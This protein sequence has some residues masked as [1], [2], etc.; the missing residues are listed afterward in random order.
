VS[1]GVL[2]LAPLD[3]WVAGGHLVSNIEMDGR[4][5]RILTRADIAA[6]GLRLGKLFPASTL[7]AADTGAING[8]AKLHG[9]G[10]SVSQMMAGANG[11]AALVMDG[12]S[13]GELTVRLAN[14]D[15]ANSLLLLVGG[16]KQIPIR[17]AVANFKAEKGIF[18]V[19]DLVLDTTKV[20]I[21]GEGN[22]NFI[23]ESLHLRLLSRAKGFSLVTLR[24]PIAVTGSFQS[25]SVRP[26]LGGVFARGGLA[27]A[28]GLA[29]GGL[30]ALLPLLDLGKDQDSK[31][32][33]LLS[34]ARADAGLKA[35]TGAVAAKK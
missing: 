25:P 5:P 13:E 3:F 7:A 34:Q 35:S 29:T 30:G 33:A 20:N 32:A 28:L 4:A 26:E 12:G 2:T 14:L 23:D 1:N 17:C 24:G 18:T 21:V 9:S 6:T 16:D 31:C 19:K 8:R 11:E 10:N 22:V 15:V 27:V